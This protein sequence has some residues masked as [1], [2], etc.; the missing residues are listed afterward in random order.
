MTKTSLY[1]TNSIFTWIAL[2]AVACFF[3][4][5]QNNSNAYWDVDIGSAR[6]SQERECFRQTQSSYDRT[7]RVIEATYSAART[8]ARD[9]YLRT[10]DRAQYARDLEIALSSYNNAL[11]SAE[12]SANA[13]REGCVR[14]G[15]FRERQRAEARRAAEAAAEAERQRQAAAANDDDEDDYSEDEDE[16]EREDA[17]D[18]DDGFDNDPR[19][20]DLLDDDIDDDLQD[21][22]DRLEELEEV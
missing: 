7:E 13:S 3:V 1:I 15:D 6:D 9:E 16:N 14:A 4:A 2:V 18:D 21:D 11:V 12:T 5:T 10:G 17:M 22:Y 19:D 8:F 20:D